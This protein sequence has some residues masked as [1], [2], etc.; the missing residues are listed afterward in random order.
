MKSA[1]VFLSTLFYVMENALVTFSGSGGE[2]GSHHQQVNVRSI[3]DNKYSAPTRREA[4]KQKKRWSEMGQKAMMLA[5]RCW[6]ISIRRRNNKLRRRGEQNAN[7]GTRHG[8]RSRMSL[9]LLQAKAMPIVR[10]NSWW[11]FFYLRDS[12]QNVSILN[13]QYFPL[14]M[15]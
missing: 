11:F 14:S 2:M 7:N 15:L 13:E 6:K 4:T 1:F 8:K 3:R 10:H 5:N 12:I 9:Q